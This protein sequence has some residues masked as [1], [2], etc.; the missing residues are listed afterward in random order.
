MELILLPSVLTVVFATI[1]I[2]MRTK[3]KV[4]PSLV[5][6]TLSGVS[7]VCTGV[8]ACFLTTFDTYAL[9]CIFGLIMGLC[10]DVIMQFKYFN[11]QTYKTFLIMGMAF[12]AIG[13]LFYL[14]AFY[15]LYAFSFIPFIV[16]FVLAFIIYKILSAKEF[17][18]LGKLRI[19]C[20]IYFFLL[21]FLLAQCVVGYIVAPTIKGL[22]LIVG[23][24]SFIISDSILGFIYFKV[25]NKRRFTVV[26]LITY[27]VA[28]L[29]I[30]LSIML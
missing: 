24:L 29:L 11:A 28:Q 19:Y 1:F 2:V 5:F 4:V 6:K 25:P 30:A 17:E 8:M 13:H 22:A 21:S 12:F 9:L 23:M 20:P 15:T 27:Y 26:N 3:K 7:F 16:A 10:G 18:R 14:S